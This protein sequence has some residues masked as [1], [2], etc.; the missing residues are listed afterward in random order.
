MGARGWHT[1]R[2]ERH[3]EVAEFLAAAE[4]YD[5]AAVALFYSAHQWV[6]SSL[7]DEPNM[8]K[9]ERHPRKHVRPAGSD[10][11][12]TNQLVREIF[13]PISVQ[14][15]SLADMSHRTRYDHDRLSESMDDRTIWPLLRAQFNEVRDFCQG[16]NKTRPKVHTQQEWS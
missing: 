11:R 13:T 16:R 14:Y 9:D 7:A 3:L 4:H 2:A 12:G 8:H 15:L 10:G 1:A 6:H 5:W